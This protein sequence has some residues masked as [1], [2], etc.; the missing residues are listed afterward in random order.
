MVEA[1]IGLDRGLLVL[2][3]CIQGHSCAIVSHDLE[4]AV[5][6]IDLTALQKQEMAEEGGC[7]WMGGYYTE[8]KHLSTIT[9]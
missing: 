3:S 4:K 6:L 1:D 9:V 7:C 5:L 2:H 8:L